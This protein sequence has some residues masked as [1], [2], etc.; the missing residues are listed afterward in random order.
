MTSDEAENVLNNFWSEIFTVLRGLRPAGIIEVA[1]PDIPAYEDFFQRNGL[2]Y[3][4]ITAAQL[5]KIRKE[6]KHD[7]LRNYRNEFLFYIGRDRADVEKLMEADYENDTCSVGI[8][9]GYPAC[10]VKK[11]DS[12][13]LE[14][15]NA[16]VARSRFQYIAH[17]PCSADCEKTVDYERRVKKEI[18]RY[19]QAKVQ[20]KTCAD[21]AV[22]PT[23]AKQKSTLGNKA[24][25]LCFGKADV[26]DGAVPCSVYLGQKCNIDCCFCCPMQGD[27]VME[28][29]SREIMSDIARIKGTISPTVTFTGGEPT[30][31]KQ[32][33]KYISTAKEL[34]FRSV[35]I[36]TNGIQLADMNYVEKLARAGLSYIRVLSISHIDKKCDEAGR[37]KGI[38]K[39]SLEAIGNSLE[40]GLDVFVI[41]PLLRSTFFGLTDHIEYLVGKFP[42][43][44]RI[45]LQPIFSGEDFPLGP[46]EIESMLTGITERRVG[47]DVLIT[48]APFEAPPPCLFNNIEKML[49]FFNFPPVDHPVETMFDKFN[50]CNNCSFNS[51]CLG[52]RPEYRKFFHTGVAHNV[53]THQASAILR[54]SQKISPTSF[55]DAE[56]GMKFSRDNLVVKAEKTGSD[57]D[58]I[59]DDVLLRVKFKCNQK[60]LFC[61]IDTSCPDPTHEQILAEINALR[62]SA[63]RINIIS[64]T[65]GEPTMNPRLPEYVSLLHDV[66]AEELSLQTNAVLLHDMEKTRALVRNGLDSAFVSL[67][68]H[69]PQ[70]SDLLTGMKGAFKKTIA[71]IDNLIECGVFVYISHVINT[72]NC[73]ML[74][75]FV[76]YVSGRLG[77]IPIVFSVAAPHNTQLLYKGIVPVF[78]DIRSHVI[79][80][81]E[82]CYRNKIPFAGFSGFCG[83]P[84]CALGGDLR[85]YPDLHRVSGRMYKNDCC[86]D[87]SLNDYC[88]GYRQLY[89]DVLGDSEICPIRMEDFRP[90]IRPMKNRLD[91]FRNFYK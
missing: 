68:S 75:D 91:F 24:F 16:E 84:P 77:G 25:D 26:S 10:C 86:T 14:S 17:I 83:A 74:P 65:G 2:F 90:E 47:G 76:E 23:G 43:I 3:K 63:R 41:I 13:G 39:A 48:F 73:T 36:R 78:P 71:G 70:V 62:D 27:T 9:L 33:I 5:N 67:H 6:R 72:M 81:V 1:E 56:Q 55:L 58:T 89:V 46:A 69:D 19:K 66:K 38:C 22:S 34:G 87:C 52:L 31:N 80:A 64:I 54:Y 42:G 7:T 18:E 61:Y 28:R 60:C 32:L 45:E 59:I 79:E 4:M 8:L 40:L 57:G 85:C 35:G 44:E 49:S 21:E 82:K 20:D 12:C 88:Y 50:V 30:V 15:M 11:L 37:S 51:I 53:N 29:S